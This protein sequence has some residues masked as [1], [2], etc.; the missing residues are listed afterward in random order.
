[1]NWKKALGLALM[2][3]L[4]AGCQVGP[5]P[6]P[7]NRPSRPQVLPTPQPLKP[8]AGVIG[9]N[10]GTLLNLE[11]GTFT[12]LAQAGLRPSGAELNVGTEGRTQPGSGLPAPSGAARPIDSEPG[13]TFVTRPSATEGVRSMQVRV[14]AALL[15]QPEASG[16]VIPP[17]GTAIYLQTADGRY[18]MPEGGA[19][20]PLSFRTDAAGAFRATDLDLPPC[21]VVLPL[22]RPDRVLRGLLPRAAEEPLPLDAAS[23]LL[24]A[25]VMRSGP[26]EDTLSP[27]SW[28]EAHKA[29]RAALAQG[30]VALGSLD[31]TPAALSRRLDELEARDPALAKALQ[32]LR[33]PASAEAV[34]PPGVETP[35][36]EAATEGAPPP[37]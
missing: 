11:G 36:G 16:E 8:V 18:L 2:T 35:S 19:S 31:W 22:D 6:L 20:E 12:S 26:P 30:K 17:E 13:N 15:G 14:P 4:T 24:A 7:P 28:L 27:T 23:T 37:P 34:P 25:R 33:E 5:Q 10:G 29:L 9:L 3:A 32:Q 21:W 1:M